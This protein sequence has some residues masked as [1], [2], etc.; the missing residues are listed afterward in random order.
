[1][2]VTRR[3]F[4]KIAL[5]G[6]PLPIAFG[7][8]DSKVNGVEIGVQS[9]SFRDRPLD[10]AV[11]AMAELG[12]SPCE[13][14]MGHVEPRQQ[15]R[16]K[17]AQAALRKWRES[18][19][20]DEF[21]QIAAKFKKAGIRLFAYTFA[22]RDQLSDKEIDY[23]FRAAKALGA[24][25]ITSSSTVSMAKRIAPF[26]EKYKIAIGMHGHSNIKDPN[27]F[28][29]PE[30]F[31]TAMS[32]SKYIGA[33]LDI[34]HFFAAGYDPV[35][36]MEKHHKRIRWR[37]SGALWTFAARRWRRLGRGKVLGELERREHAVV[38]LFFGRPAVLFQDFLAPPGIQGTG[39]HIQQQVD[40]PGL[41]GVAPGLPAQHL[42]NQPSEPV[43]GEF[44]LA[45]FLGH[46]ALIG[47]RAPF[48]LSFIA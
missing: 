34:G 3:N 14:W 33:N 44:E 37:K 38:H 12:L 5:A 35:A 28:A 36:F 39:F 19:S 29:K 20:M 4:G 32:Y 2:I 22:F 24:N 41:K 46:S 6:L 11:K 26:A 48:M 1:M 42:F 9:Y 21:K 45:G 13:L 18:V 17:E 15:G 47:F 27:E 25:Y 43:Q 16:G 40:L 31:E 10:D 8:R 30:S 7:K 23:A